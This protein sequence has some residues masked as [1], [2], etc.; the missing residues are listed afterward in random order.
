MTAYQPVAAAEGASLPVVAVSASADDGNVPANTIDCDLGT[1]WSGEGDGVWIQYDL[2]SPRDVGSVTIA[3]HKGNT[4]TA[5]FDV[6]LSDDGSSW[7]TVL[8]SET[9]SGHALRPELR[10]EW[11]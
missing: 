6:R 10:Q 7:T 11:S 1:R 9:S 4:R 5:T 3:W 8:D 2:G